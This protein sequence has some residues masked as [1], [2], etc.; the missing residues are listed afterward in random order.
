MKCIKGYLAITLKRCCKVIPDFF[1]D[2]E[3]SDEVELYSGD[4]LQMAGCSLVQLGRGNAWLLLRSP[5]IEFVWLIELHL[6][7]S[8]E[9]T[10]HLAITLDK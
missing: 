2:M 7:D 10:G 9:K 3:L 5:K 8:F 4:D 1:M 6:G